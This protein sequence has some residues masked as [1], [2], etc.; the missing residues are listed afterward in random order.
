MV[1][2]MTNTDTPS[3]PRTA[4]ATAAAQTAAAR[5]RTARFLASVDAMPADTF[6]DPALTTSLVRLA[7]R[8]ANRHGLEIISER[9]P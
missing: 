6:D 3:P 7:R 2:G 5:R 1:C 9:L 4:A 8:I